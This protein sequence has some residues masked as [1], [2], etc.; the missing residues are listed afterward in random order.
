MK[1]LSRLTLVVLALSLPLAAQLAA[2][3]RSAARA[4]DPSAAKTLAALDKPVVKINEAVLVERDV[5][6]EMYT[7]FPYARQHGGSF[8]KAMEADIRKGALKMIIFEELAYQEA[9]RRGMTVS[10]ARLDQAERQFRKQF[11]NANEY[12][13][14]LQVEHITSRQ[15]L[16]GKIRRSLMIEKFLQQEVTDKAAVSE[17]GAKA[18]YD[19]NQEKFRVPELF[20]VQTISAV[21]KKDSTPEQRAD[22][23]KRAE[24]ALREARTKKT[25]DEFGLLAEKISEDDYRVMMGD[26]HLVPAD[27]LPPQLMTVL[28]KMKTGD[29]SDVIDIDGQVFTIVRLHARVAAQMRKFAEIKDGL[30]AKLQKDRTEKLRSELNARLQKAARIQ[31]L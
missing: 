15:M 1:S 8:P 26:H 5:L 21:V 16:R 23:R 28:P 30:R 19:Q 6:R 18:F 12:R 24:A 14:F 22:A 9:Q 25:Y 13:G 4:V 17:A 29:I 27:R 10:A 2:S 11:P 31:E 3:H 20:Q 7:I